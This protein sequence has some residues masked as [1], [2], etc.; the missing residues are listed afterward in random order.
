MGEEEERHNTTNSHKDAYPSVKR[1]ASVG[2]DSSSSQDTASEGGR[3]GGR[4]GGTAAAFPPRA[5]P[6][7]QRKLAAAGTDE[8]VSFPDDSPAPEA[9][10]RPQ[11]QQQQQ[12][13]PPAVAVQMETAPAAA[14][15]VAL[16]P[17]PPPPERRLSPRRAA[18]AAAAL[19]PP[20]LLGVAASASAPAASAPPPAPPSQLPRPTTSSHSHSPLV[21]LPPAPGSFADPSDPTSKTF[22]IPSSPEQARRRPF[23]MRLGPGDD[24]ALS[25]LAA[26]VQATAPRRRPFVTRAL[27]MPISMGICPAAVWGAARPALSLFVPKK[28]EVKIA[29][30][31]T[32]VR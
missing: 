9:A 21:P 1:P 8:A 3:V 4:E 2:A 24:E 25:E 7:K 22:V 13:S 29:S 14:A 19:L 28:T 15:P 12:F 32:K 30:D 17:P 5:S 11:Q 16:L 6:Y 31:D 26:A 10:Q 18:A 23:C 27:A 20:P